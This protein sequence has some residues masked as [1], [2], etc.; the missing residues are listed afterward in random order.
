MGFT[1]AI[2]LLRGL[3]PTEDLDIWGAAKDVLLGQRAEVFMAPVLRKLR[4]LDARVASLVAPQPFGG[5]GR[6]WRDDLEEAIS[7]LEH[8]GPTPGPSE[9]PAYAP[10][11][12]HLLYPPQEASDPG[13]WPWYK[14]LHGLLH[15]ALGTSS[16]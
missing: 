8:L 3:W 1:P 16:P 15:G 5:R 12:R 4:E 6:Y 14:Y 2:C 11:V 7:V 10:E 13:L 9:D